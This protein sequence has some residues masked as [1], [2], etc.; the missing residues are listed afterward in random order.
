MITRS[1]GPRGLDI[2]AIH[3][4][5]ATARDN[6]QRALSVIRRHLDMDIAFISEFIGDWRFMHY[7][8]AQRAGGPI[9]VGDQISLQ[10][11]YCGKIVEGTLPE[12]IVDTAELPEAM[13][14]P[15]TQKIPIGAH[16]S[17]PLRLPNGELFGTFCC[18]NFIARPDLRKRDLETLREVADKVGKQIDDNN[19]KLTLTKLEAILR[20]NKES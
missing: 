9:S 2:S 4:F 20:R 1:Q 12:L 18:F 5:H 13:A 17:V 16:M 19:Y 15:D 7:V 10:D 14:I 3:A 11:G 6:I 8:D